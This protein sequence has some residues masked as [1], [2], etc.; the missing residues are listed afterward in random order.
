VPLGLLLPI[1][2][3]LTSL[4]AATAW[5]TLRPLYRTALPAFAEVALIAT[6]LAAPVALSF[7]QPETGHPAALKGTGPEL[8]RYVAICLS[9]G[10]TLTGLVWLAVRALDRRALDAGGAPWLAGATGV[11]V[12]TLAL[13]LHCAIPTTTH[14][15]LA[16]AGVG[17]VLVVVLW[18]WQRIHG[19][20]LARDR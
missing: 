6:C 5:A 10:V 15:L 7:L 1:V 19:R 14:W 12:A 11:V 4:F 8:F 17:A 20:E 13:E 16:H 3:A 2:I 9:H 18:V